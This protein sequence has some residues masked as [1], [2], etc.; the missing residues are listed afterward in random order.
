MKKLLLFLLALPAFGQVPWVA[1]V[2]T[3]VSASA[4]YVI[5]LQQAGQNVQTVQG[6][7]ISCGVNTFT[8][9]QAQNGAAATATSL[10]QTTTGTVAPSSNFFGVLSPSSLNTP[11]SLTAWVASNVSAGTPLGGI[12]PFSSTAVLGPLP[13]RSY[14]AAL[15]SN[16]TSQ[17]YTVTVTNTGSGSCTLVADIYG[18]QA[19]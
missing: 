15:A 16:Q 17:N 7:V 8:L 14:I 1:H 5:T 10:A 18:V 13:G 6:A 12:Q 11:L 19:Q 3:T 4:S 9:S 2:T